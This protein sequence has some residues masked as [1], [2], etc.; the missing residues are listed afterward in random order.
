MGEGVK[1]GTWALE[2]KYWFVALQVLD[3]M[4]VI[5]KVHGFGMKVLQKNI[6]DNLY[7]DKEINIVLKLEL[8]SIYFYILLQWNMKHLFPCF[9]LVIC[10]N[11]SAAVNISQHGQVDA[12]GKARTNS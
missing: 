9:K 7:I 2:N 1:R 5:M 8:V 6:L 11:C 10:M 12:L 4:S 3:I